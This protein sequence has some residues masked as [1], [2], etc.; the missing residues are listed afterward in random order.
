MNNTNPINPFPVVPDGVWGWKI[1]G[2]VCLIFAGVAFARDITKLAWVFLLVSIGS[3]LMIF[4]VVIAS[5][6]VGY[7]FF[8]MAIICALI[9]NE[10]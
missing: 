2:L 7:V 10:N 1:L 4:N 6:I 3:M 8:G 9:P 5:V